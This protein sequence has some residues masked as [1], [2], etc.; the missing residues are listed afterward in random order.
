MARQPDEKM[1]PPITEQKSPV[2]E[3]SETAT[4]QDGDAEMTVKGKRPA[5]GSPPTPAAKSLKTTREAVP[6]APFYDVVE[7][8]VKGDCFYIP[9]SQGLASLSTSEKVASAKD[10]AAGGRMQSAVRL[11]GVKAAKEGQIVDPGRSRSELLDLVGTS[12]QPTYSTC[13]RLVAAGVKADIEIWAKG[14]KGEWSLFGRE[15]GAGRKS[16][17][18]WLKLEDEHYEWLKPKI[19]Q[20]T[21]KEEHA[22]LT[23][24]SRTRAF[25]NSTA[26]LQG[27]GQD[28]DIRSILGLSVTPSSM[29]TAEAR[30]LLGLSSKLDDEVKRMLGIGDNDDVRK[31]LFQDDDM[32][33]VP[34]EIYRCVWAG[35]RIMRKVT[36]VI[37]ESDA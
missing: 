3:I 29:L 33:Y 22:T 34:G 35:S 19:L 1:F 30:S 25:S 24:E 37:G 20:G 5:T 23:E 11:A 14:S 10:Q 27:K 9:V 26:G 8:E 4:E 6:F 2:E 18:I 32:P 7:N 12:G 15:P 13:V 17:E 31:E 16:K 28:E 21:Q 36:R